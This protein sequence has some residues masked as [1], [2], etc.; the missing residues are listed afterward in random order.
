MRK[1]LVKLENL[2]WRVGRKVKRTVY[3][4]LGPEPDDHDPI[5]G[6]L[7]TK[8]LAEAAVRAHNDELRRAGKL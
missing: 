1:R 4:Q 8:A 3:A 2:P 5:I 6:L 7:D